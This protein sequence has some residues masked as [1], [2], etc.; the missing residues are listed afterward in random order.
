MSGVDK[1]HFWNDFIKQHDEDRM[2]VPYDE[3]KDADKVRL[4]LA[5][6]LISNYRK[7]HQQ[8]MSY[9]FGRDL[10]DYGL[11]VTPENKVLLTDIASIKPE[12]DINQR[13]GDLS[14]R[15]LARNGY[16]EKLLKPYPK[17]QK[18]MDDLSFNI[19]SR[20]PTLSGR[21]GRDEANKG[22]TE[23]LEGTYD[24]AD[25]AFDD[26]ELLT[27][28]TELGRD[29]QKRFDDQGIF[30]DSKEVSLVDGSN[31]I[32]GG[33]F[34]TVYYVPGKTNMAIKYV[35]S[36][37]AL[38]NRVQGIPPEQEFE[39]GKRAAEIGLGP[40][41]YGIQKDNNRE[42]HKIGI[43]FLK[44]HKEVGQYFLDL[45]RALK[46]VT[47]DERQK[48]LKNGY[49]TSLDVLAKIKKLHLAGISHG[50]LNKRNVLI[51]PDN[52][53]SLI[54]WG[55]SSNGF[56]AV[57]DDVKN[58]IDTTEIHEPIVDFLNVFNPVMASKITNK[59]KDFLAEHEQRR[60]M[61]ELNTEEANKE[62]VQKYY[63][64][65]DNI[66][67]SHQEN[68]D[69]EVIK[70]LLGI[71][72][73]IKGLISKSLINQIGQETRMDREESRKESPAMKLMIKRKG[74]V[75]KMRGLDQDIDREQYLLLK[76]EAADLLNQVD[77]LG[78]LTGE[79]AQVLAMVH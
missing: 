55:A 11:A 10:D 75:R 74:I 40:R 77:A 59:N 69:D 51:S 79:E 67:Q 73:D 52:K 48:L 72:L 27:H 32:G 19:Y 56:K 26:P 21:G 34:G 43:E 36:K 78:G 66:I 49:D 9:A 71:I 76:Q 39:F 46:T 38:H 70:G 41:Y 47:G 54:D 5:R 63:D 23:L 13:L 25:R 14:K 4:D 24:D 1:S 22:L 37:P 7:L 50:D 6:N 8:G 2:N 61:P 20:G 18:K 33:S 3:R 53:S 29:I 65:L 45:T 58:N 16:L 57:K 17:L 15:I 12:A 64:D 42:E 28:T 44:D 68:R 62:L 30:P 31:L 35:K 60:T